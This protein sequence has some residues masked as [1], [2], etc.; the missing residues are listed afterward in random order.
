MQTAF[1]FTVPFIRWADIADFTPRSVMAPRLI[2]DHELVYVV[3]GHGNVILNGRSFPAPPDT[4]F[5]I[6]PREWHCFQ[7]GEEN[8]GLLGIHFDWMPQPDQMRFSVHRDATNVDQDASLFREPHAIEG[9][10]QHRQPFLNLKNHNQVRRSLDDILS[11]YAGNDGIARDDS[12]RLAAGALLAATLIQIGQQAQELRQQALLLPYGPDALRRIERARAL[13]E[14][15]DTLLSIEEVAVRVGWSADHLRRMFRLLLKTT[16]QKCQT[17]ARMRR[18]KEL[19]RA[20]GLPIAEVAAR[21]GF[22]DASHFARVFKAQNG[23]TPREFLAM[24]KK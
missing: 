23:L 4:L 10:D 13:L 11:A 19:L 15:P 1:P 8:W 3:N 24:S 9:W 18:S 20:G 7:S 21:C 6:R 14:D 17:Q 16:P 2:Y 12:A 22:D 5:Y